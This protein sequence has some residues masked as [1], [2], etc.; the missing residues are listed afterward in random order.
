MFGFTKDKEIK[1]YYIVFKGR[2]QGV[3]FRWFAQQTATKL[4]ITGWVR[5]LDNGNVDCEVQ[6]TQAQVDKFIQDLKNAN[7]WIYIASYSMKQ[8]PVQ[9]DSKFIMRN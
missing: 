2:V 6:G 1:R 5:N 8:I 9:A 4:G 3:G 7:R